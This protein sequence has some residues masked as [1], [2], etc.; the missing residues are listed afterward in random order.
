MINS[1]EDIEYIC[2]VM[3][4][5]FKIPVYYFDKNENL[6]YE[7]SSNLLNNPVYPLNKD[8]IIQL[9]SE[10]KQHLFP[11]HMDS[12]YLEK[13]FSINIYLKDQFNGSIIVGPV[14]NFKMTE[15]TINGIYKDL[16]L[17]VRKEEMVH[18][19]DQLQI[20]SNF[21]FFNV[22]M[23]LYFMIYDKKL[24][25]VDILQKNEQIEKQRVDKEHAAIHITEQRQHNKVHMDI[26]IEKKVFDYVRM[27]RKKEL[28]E[29]LH[30]ILKQGKIA[31]LAKTSYLRSQKNLGIGVITLATRAA[32]EGGL[33]Q[34]IAY[35]L[36][37]FYI[38]KLEDLN[39]S[40]AV[41][42]LTESALLEFAE[43]VENSKKHKYSKPINI[44]L[45]YIFNHIYE[46]ISL[47]QLAELTSMNSNYLS[48]LFKKELGITLRHYIL[49]TK[50]DEAKNLLTYTKHSFT[51]I[52]ILLN[53][54]DQ[55][56]FIKVFKKFAGVTP[57]QYR[58]GIYR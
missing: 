16:Y 6:L 26:S 39:E 5:S 36:S 23:L 34:E 33:F 51:E 49:Q 52:S 54:H 43:R 4:N 9:F 19:Y 27:G 25:L 7:A 44:C 48:G 30:A 37:D 32:V 28:R 12:I 21:E 40:K 1:L 53:F 55:S 18:Y 11:V 38:Q 41:S 45:N 14:I 8:D 13:F 24:E 35:N 57:K 3:F 17:K 20:M 10:T 56:H 2:K 22:S 46:D 42:Q 31:T 29:T 47:S 15:G 58:N 50:I